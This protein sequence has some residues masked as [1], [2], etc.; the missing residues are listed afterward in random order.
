[1]KLLEPFEWG[2]ASSN[3]ASKENMRRGRIHL[4]LLVVL[5]GVGARAASGE[6]DLLRRRRAQKKNRNMAARAAITTGMATAALRAEEQEMLVHFVVWETAPGLIVELGAVTAELVVV[7][8]V[9][10][11]LEVWEVME[12]D[13]CISEGGV[14]LVEVVSL[15]CDEIG[16]VVVACVF[17][18]DDGELDMADSVMVFAG[19]LDCELELRCVVAG[20]GVATDAVEVS[21]FV[22]VAG[23]DVGGTG[24]SL[25]VCPS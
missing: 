6:S 7:A 13:K 20:A 4:D 19:L 14:V 10:D 12:V 22:C 16:C 3:S 24:V 1:M 2:R 17:V 21:L 23:A 11:E 8:N 5:A 15:D 18:A 25:G 9:V